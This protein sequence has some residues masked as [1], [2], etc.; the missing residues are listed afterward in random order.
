MDLSSEVCIAI[1]N[2]AGASTRPDVLIEIRTRVLS[3]SPAFLED[4]FTGNRLTQVWQQTT[5]RELCET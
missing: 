2:E 4:D 3:E 1:S 5:G